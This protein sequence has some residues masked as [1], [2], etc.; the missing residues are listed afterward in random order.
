MVG[1]EKAPGA[2]PGR[3]GA[4]IQRSVKK[5]SAIPASQPA[6]VASIDAAAEAPAAEAPAA[7]V[8]TAEPPAAMARTPVLLSVAP[9]AM[10]PER[11]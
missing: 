5:R 1:C 6:R 10:P 9:E 7:E 8:E 11:W 2:L 3:T 4:S